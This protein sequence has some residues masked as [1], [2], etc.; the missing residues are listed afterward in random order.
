VT[1]I[2]GLAGT[3]G[4]ADGT[5]ENA[6]FFGPTSIA[7]DAG[8]NLYLTEYWAHTIRK[9]RPLGTNW[10]V[11]TLAGHAGSP[12]SNDGTNSDARFNH[13]SGIAA[14]ASGTLY[15]AD[16]YNHTIRK[17]SPVGTNWV[18]T[19]IGGTA[20]VSGSDDGV[21]GGALFH[22]PSDVVVDP[23]GNLYVTDFNNLTL[24]LGR[25]SYALDIAQLANQI[26]ISWP[27]A[28]SNFVLETASTLSADAAWTSLT[29]GIIAS[30][31]RFTLTNA[32]SQPSGFYRL[33]KQLE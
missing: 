21:G 27:L 10:V 3:N 16:S 4:T 32:T 20:G 23:S 8:G 13:P 7:L 15:V 28:A 2:A 22:T 26:V 5:N 29:N 30:G 12:G 1:T 14:D 31:E 11:S 17:I 9:I 19:T 24:R 25:P 6:R 33:R 18:V